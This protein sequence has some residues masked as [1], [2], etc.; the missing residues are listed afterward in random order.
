M[1]TTSPE[2]STR[3][4]L[5]VV[6][7]SP[8]VRAEGADTTDHYDY[9]KPGVLEATVDGEPMG[10]GHFT[11]IVWK[12][13]TK[14]GCAAVTCGDGTLFTGYGDVSLLV[15]PTE[16]KLTCSPHLWSVNTSRLETSTSRATTPMPS[17]SRMSVRK[18]PRAYTGR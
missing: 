14:I 5:R 10:L 16:V 17:L 9:S 6:R 7:L 15:F 3:G 4:P 1:V 2:P 12:A 18:T 13:T 11:Q 8:F